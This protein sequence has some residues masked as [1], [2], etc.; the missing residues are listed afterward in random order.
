M[1]LILTDKGVRAMKLLSAALALALL[2]AAAGPLPGGSVET[3]QAVYLGVADYGAPETR[4]ENRDAFS[5]RFLIGGEEKR[6]RLDDADGYPLQNALKEGYRYTLVLDG[7]VVRAAQERAEQIDFAPIAAGTPGVRTLKNLLQTALA[8]VGAALYV[9]GGGWDWQDEGA[10]PQARTLG[11]SSDWV[12]FFRAQDASYTYK[13]SD[14]THSY[15]PYG[16]FN[17]YYY[18]GLD[19]SGYLGWV[20]YNV[21]ES[22]SGRAGYVTGST[23][24]AASLAERGWGTRSQR[25]TVSDLRPGCIM[26]QNGHV[27]LSLG[28]CGDGSALILH[29]TPDGGPQLSAL[30]SDRS[31]EAW[32]LA[33]AYMKTYCPDWSARYSAQLR[34]PAAY[35]SF[36]GGTAGLFTWDETVLPDPDGVGALE[37]AALLAALFGE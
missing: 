24:F 25:V 1:I 22:E 23:G 7:D 2:L 9:Y 4:K 5:Y 19:C 3:A 29:S 16:R 17:E 15:Y 8:P 21:F 30:G 14:P 18:A 12:R 33:S 32:R 20:L 34:N 13:N 27:W 11:V 26:S 37:P 6:L 36:S 31:C 35:L 28:V 10:G